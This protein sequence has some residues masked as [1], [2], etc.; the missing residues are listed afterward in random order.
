[1]AELSGLQWLCVGDIAKQTECFEGYDDRL[2]C[3]VLDDDKLLDQ[4]EPLMRV[5]GNIVDYHS[6]DLFPRRWFDVV[7]VLRTDNTLLYDRL[8]KRGYTGEK[9]DNNV[10]CEIFQTLLDEAR[11]SYDTHIVHELSSNTVDDLSTNVDS[12]SRWIHAWSDNYT[13]QL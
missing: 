6:C 2:N 12:I 10:Q 5:G 11:D 9:L 8:S 1:M 7:F 3:P 4:L 13:A